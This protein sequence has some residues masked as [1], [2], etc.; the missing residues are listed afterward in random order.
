EAKA[1][2]AGSDRLTLLALGAGTVVTHPL[3]EK[4][5]IV[6]GRGESADVRV[7]EASI[8]RRHAI[9]TIDAGTL[10]IEDLG[11]ANGTKVR[12][13]VLAA[14]QRVTFAPGDLIELGSMMFVVQRPPHLTQPRHVWNHGYFEGRLGEECARAARFDVG[15]AVVRIHADDRSKDGEIRAV[16]ASLTESSDVLAADGPSEFEALLV[17]GPEVR[18]RVV[19]VVRRIEDELRARSIDVTVGSSCHPR[20]GRDP[21]SLLQAANTRVRGVSA[22]ATGAPMVVRDPRMQQLHRLLERVAIGTINV[23]LLGETGVGTDV[24]AAR[25]HALS[26]RAGGPFVALNCAALSETLLES[27]LFGHERGAFTGAVAAKKGLLEMAEQGTVFLDE[28]GELPMTLQVKL[29][30]VLEER[31]VRRV[32]GLKAMPID[33]RLVSATNRDLE[34]E[35]AAGRFRQDLYFRLNGVSLVIP[36]LRE[37]TG[38]ID[39]LARTFVLEAAKR[40]KRSPAPVISP[41]ALALLRGYAWPGNVR[42]LRNVIERAVLLCSEQSILPEHLPVDKMQATVSIE[43]SPSSFRPAPPPARGDSIPPVVARRSTMPPAPGSSP[44][45]LKNAVDDFERQRILDALETCA[46]N[47]SRAAKM[48]GISRNTLILRLKTYGIKRPRAP[49]EEGAPD[50]GGDDPDD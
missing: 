46:G 11:S 45:S 38:E 30:R 17:G 12:D 31:A 26:P 2:P 1:G 41:E 5:A 23:M 19:E 43:S 36:P 44:F 25:V 8:S 42:E 7:A 32:G 27:E 16:L 48:L 6:I 20:D 3:P 50:S 4:G 10:I 15:L 37:R 49:R 28:L 34:A 39:E 47:Q 35:V 22:R 14:H 9:V 29:L 33:V 21:A 40:E 13:Q 24:M 18:K